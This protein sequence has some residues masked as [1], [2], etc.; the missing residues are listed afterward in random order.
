MKI[1]FKKCFLIILFLL[2]IYSTFSLKYKLYINGDSKERE[3]VLSSTIWHLQKEGYTKD[4][5]K[6]IRVDYNYFKGGRLPYSVEVVFY[7]EP[8]IAYCYNW[9]N[10]NKTEVARLGKTAAK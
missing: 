7:K 1:S 2:L 5:I 8:H 10:L 9:N 4:K 3:K 6:S